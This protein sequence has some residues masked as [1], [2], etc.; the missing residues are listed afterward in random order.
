MYT[1]MFTLDVFPNY[2][3][4][5]YFETASLTECRAHLL[6]WAG[7]RCRALCLAL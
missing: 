2:C 7:Y 3:T 4:P 5:Y 1:C 6:G